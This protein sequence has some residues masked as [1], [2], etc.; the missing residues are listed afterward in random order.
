MYLKTGITNTEK[1]DAESTSVFP[2][3]F[4]DKIEIRVP[5]IINEYRLIVFDSSGKPASNHQIDKTKSSGIDLSLLTEGVYFIQLL[6]ESKVFKT[7]RV[8]K[9]K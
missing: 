1:T 9:N 3:P 7:V 4:T 6:S 2:N 8:L 5:E